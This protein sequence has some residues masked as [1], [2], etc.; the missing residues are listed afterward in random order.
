M[1]PNITHFVVPAVQPCVVRL[2]DSLEVVE[3]QFLTLL[4]EGK[5]CSRTLEVI[6][7]L[8]ANIEAVKKCHCRTELLLLKFLK[9]LWM[10]LTAT[11]LQIFTEGNCLDHNGCIVRNHEDGYSLR[12]VDQVPGK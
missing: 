4:Q 7:E 1:I 2:T 8:F 11:G 3:V 6:C 5:V 9:A 10:V 12:E